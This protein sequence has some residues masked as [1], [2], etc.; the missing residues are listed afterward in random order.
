MDENFL[1][2]N[3]QIHPK[4]P[5]FKADVRGTSRLNIVGENNVYLLV[6]Y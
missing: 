2:A 3:L 5:V 1:H 4:S 6:N